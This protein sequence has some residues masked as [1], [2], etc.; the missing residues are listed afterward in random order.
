MYDLYSKIQ[1]RPYIF[2][3]NYSYG[4]V[5]VT[6]YYNEDKKEMFFVFQSIKLYKHLIKWF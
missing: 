6:F 2:S 4:V 3:Y 5:S 1:N